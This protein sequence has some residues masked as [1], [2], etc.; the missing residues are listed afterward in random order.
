MLLNYQ[1]FLICER[2]N[3]DDFLGIYWSK[4]ANFGFGERVI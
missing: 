4:S 1:N 3:K 2:L